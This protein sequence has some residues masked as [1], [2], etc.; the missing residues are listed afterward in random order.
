[1]G[2]AWLFRPVLQNLLQDRAVLINLSILLEQVCCLLWRS[3]WRRLYLRERNELD[4]S[5]SSSASL[6]ATF[7]HQ[8]LLCAPVV[9]AGTAIQAGDLQPEGVPR[10]PFA[11]GPLQSL[12]YPIAH[13]APA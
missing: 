7:I 12:D 11:D 3:G 10:Q 2:E 4:P 5:I 8:S 13:L 1:M 6:D 9:V